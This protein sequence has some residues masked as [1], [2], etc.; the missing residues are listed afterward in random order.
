MIEDYKPTWLIERIYHIKPADFQSRGFKAVLVDLD[1][2]LIAWDNP[3][4][5]KELRDWLKEM[6]EA[7]MPVLVV[8]N[9]NAKRVKKAVEPFGILFISRAMKPF[10][11]GIKRA[12]KQLCLNK[13]EVVFIGDQL[14]TDIRAA[15]RVG[16]KSIL[17]RP[18]VES[19]AWSTKINRAREKRVWRKLASSYDMRFQD[20]L[21]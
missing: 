5:T 3:N 15:N 13:N 14:M 6:A 21:I 11:L 12:L 19:D 8:S 1:N 17:V 16:I 10:S 9:N 18:L 2:T 4:G 7:E 20:K